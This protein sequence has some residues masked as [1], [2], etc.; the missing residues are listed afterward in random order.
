[1]KLIIL[2]LGLIISSH[3]FG[4]DYRGKFQPYWFASNLYIKPVDVTKT[5]IPSCA[6][7]VLLRLQED[8]TSEA[9]KYKYTMLLS[10]WVA[11]KEIRL[12]GTNGCTT[13]GD[14][15]IYAV[16]VPF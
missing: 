10:M 13:E 9:F 16:N 14:E 1:M 3:S 15:I 7:R 5:N 4:G 2:V 6:T 8:M 11:Q 12:I